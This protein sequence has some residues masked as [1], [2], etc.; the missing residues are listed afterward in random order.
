MTHYILQNY[1]WLIISIL[2]ALLV[3][4]LF[5][6]GGQSMLI[7]AKT[8]GQRSMMVNSLGRKWEFTFTT[9]VTFGGAFFASFP[10]FYSTSF[11]GAYW[12]WMF[13]LFSFVIQAVAYEYRSKHGNIYGSKFYDTLLLI[14][15]IVGPVLLG[16][17]VAG[18]FFG[19]EFTVTK[20]NILNVQSA[21]ISQWGSA[22]GLEAIVCW[23]NLI[24]GFMVFFLARTLASLYF[25][26][27][28]DDEEVRKAQRKHL[29]INAP[30]FVVLFL[31]SLVLIC[32]AQGVQVD[33]NGNMATA[34]NKYLH[35]YL[36]MWWC[37][38]L[39]LI[40][41]GMVLYGIGKTLLK[42]D[43]NHGIW[44]SGIGT[45]TVV[46][47]LF[48]VLGF[49]GTA[50]YPSTIDVNSSLNLRNSSSSLFT[51][52]VMSYVSILVPFVLAYI[53]VAWHKMDH[54]KITQ[55]EIDTT[56]PDDKY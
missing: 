55:H 4:L 37:L 1:W 12:L 28:I 50:Y 54:N 47:T 36:E 33:D 42:P 23:K 53:A 48:W 29:L 5:V 46:L 35:N 25:I 9:L 44:F 49:N 22:H 10:L 15:G 26:N 7:H 43:Y 41:V 19:N 8:D 56:D 34:P 32:T 51:L 38:A 40:G 6:Q 3:F 17:A 16:V 24:F 27:N 45:V 21:T 2:G 11:G 13:I 14:N 30:I 39:L 31:V 52:R 18:M 20:A